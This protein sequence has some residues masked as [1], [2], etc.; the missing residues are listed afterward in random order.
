LEVIDL[1][2]NGL[3]LI[4]PRIFTDERGYFLELLQSQRYATALGGATFVQD[5]L[6]FSRRGVLR[7][8]HYQFPRWQ[9]KLVSVVQGEIYDVVVDVRRESPT[10]GRWY[11][12][13]LR[14]GTHE[15]LWV[16]AGFAH[17]FCV[18]SEQAYVLYK[19]TDLYDPSGEHT[20]LATDP[21]LGIEWPIAE[22]TLSAKDAAGR[23]LKDA[24]LP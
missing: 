15:Q 13:A 21:D 11:G 2:L 1:P 6:S 8:L 19:C 4:R 3:K 18:T 12:H 10:F 9:G 7:G 22:P 24:V 14:G 17:G 23:R 20:I 5:N 16:P